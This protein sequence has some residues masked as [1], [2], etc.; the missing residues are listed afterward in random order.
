M[1]AHKKNLKTLD[2]RCP[3]CGQKTLKLVQVNSFKLGVSYE[4]KEIVC[5]TCE[6]SEEYH[7]SQ[8]RFKDEFNIPNW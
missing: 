6:Y 5:T 8:K 2:R 3:E 7:E 1:E 4:S